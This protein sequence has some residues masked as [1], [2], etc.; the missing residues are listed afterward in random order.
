MTALSTTSLSS[1]G[2]AALETL[3][4]CLPADLSRVAKLREVHAACSAAGVVDARSASGVLAVVARV[5][6]RVVVVAHT[7]SKAGLV[8]A[9]SSVPRA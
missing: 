7:A 1:A 8:V 4:S 6:S 5:A 3:V 2:E 9:W